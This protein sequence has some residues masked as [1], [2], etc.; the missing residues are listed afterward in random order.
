M[1]AE[2]MR[3]PS[4]HVCIKGNLARHRVMWSA[5]VNV[6]KQ[7]V[8]PCNIRAHINCC[9]RCQCK[10]N[11]GARTHVVC[12]SVMLSPFRRIRPALRQLSICSLYLSPDMQTSG[13]HIR[14]AGC[15]CCMKYLK[16]S[17]FCASGILLLPHQVPGS[18]IHQSPAWPFLDFTSTNDT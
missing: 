10:A 7:L 3:Q 4:A 18:C 5:L 2:N 11:A 6:S 1:T 9:S 13:K 15:K 17:C 12:I 16:V 8:D 14:T